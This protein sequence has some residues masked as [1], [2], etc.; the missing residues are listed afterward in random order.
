MPQIFNASV[1]FLKH[2]AVPHVIGTHPQ[3]EGAI[4]RFERVP[5]IN[6][7][8]IIV[9]NG[10]AFRTWK[11]IVKDVICNQ[12]TPSGLRLVVQ[13]LNSNMGLPN[14]TLDYDWVVEARYFFGT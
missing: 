1:N 11:G 9:K 10:H 6:K 7:E 12:Q 13:L 3:D 8:I 2:A 14:M 5:W 4:G